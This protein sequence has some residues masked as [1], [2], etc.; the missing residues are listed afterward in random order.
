VKKHFCLTLL[1]PALTK[2]VLV[3]IVS[4]YAS[5]NVFEEAQ[6]AAQSGRYDDV[7]TTLTG[8]IEMNELQPTELVVAYSNR[9]IAYSLLKAYAMA[10]ADFLR[11][12]EINPQ[13]KLALNHLG[14]LA[15][16]VHKDYR[17]A[18]AWY[19][20]ASDLG[21][22]GS[23]VNLANLYR[24]G[25]GSSVDYSAAFDL[26]QL[27]AEQQYT[28]AFVPIGIMYMEGLGVARSYSEG[29]HWLEKGKSEGII[30]ANY[31]LGTAY[32]NGTGVQRDYKT[33]SG[34]YHIAA[35]QGHGKAQN[36][37]GYLHRQGLGTIQDYVEAAKWYQLA[38]DQG[39]TKAMNRLAW[40]MAT[41]PVQEICD[42]PGA[43]KMALKAVSQ[44]DSP[45]NLDTLAAAYARAG[46][47]DKA[48]ETIR[49]IAPSSDGNPSRYARRLGLYQQGLPYQ[50]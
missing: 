50:L 12:L 30:D 35:I 1:V 31:Y 27:A 38:A 43:V 10:E 46:E 42:G 20:K 44:D 2:F 6:L 14:I 33:A 36:A 41:C 16:H 9:G 40:L 11:A 23:Q 32:V 21:F 22:P 15:E 4:Q 8:A 26:Y 28:L 49:N 19:K 5:A 24:L 45:V 39:V 48:T 7:V 29:L 3:F 13:Y 18:R 47:F 37:L 17:K 25:R 34:L